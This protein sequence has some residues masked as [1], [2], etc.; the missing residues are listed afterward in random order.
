MLEE[1]LPA[2]VLIIRVLH[3]ALAKHLVR[4]VVGVFEYHQPRHQPR[5]QRR[6]TGAVR[7]GLP[8]RPLQECPVC[9][10][11]QPHQRMAQIDDLVQPRS[12]QV[13]FARLT[14]F[15]WLHRAPQHRIVSNAGNHESNLQG[16]AIRRRSFRQN[17]LLLA[18]GFR[19]QINGLEIL[20]GRLH[21]RK[22][23]YTR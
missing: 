19:F 11:R 21:H 1:L 23:F 22:R 13:L 20:R 4:Q 3:P 10:A 7:V 8:K 5:G 17:R 2:E 14:T 12:E 15:P 6:L 18:V 9:L 16:I